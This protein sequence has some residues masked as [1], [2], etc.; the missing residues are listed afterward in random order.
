MTIHAPLQSLGL[1]DE[2]AA[3]RRAALGANRIEEPRSRSLA[4][5]I[6]GA[7]REPMFLLLFAAT[8]LYLLLGDLAEGLFLLAGAT[9]A[10]GLVVAQQARSERALAAL[11]LLAEP[12]ARVLRSSVERRLP[13]SDLVPDDVILVGEGERLPADAMLISGDALQV[14]ESALT[15]ES[16]PVVK[17]PALPAAGSRDDE[18]VAR[19]YAGTMLVQG[20]GVAVVLRTGQQTRIGAIGQSLAGIRQEPT[21]LQKTSAGLVGRLGVAAVAFCVLVALAYGLLRDDWIGGALAG[22]TVGISLIPEEFPMVLAIFLALGA[23]RLARHQVLVRRPA[24]IETLGAV[25]L[26][27]VD[28]TGTLTENRMSVVAVWR[29][30]RLWRCEDGALAGP[31][32]G[33]VIEIAALASAVRPSDPMDRAVREM[34]TGSGI[35]LAE[36][37]PLRSYPL[38]PDRLAFIQVWPQPSSGVLLAAKGAPEAICR[39]CGLSADARAAVEQTVV[40]MAAAGLRVLG[41]AAL[42]RSADGGEDPGDLAFEF[43]GLVGFQDPVRADVPPA[44]AQARAAGISVVMITGDYPATAVEIAR[45]CGIDVTAGVLTGAEIDAL[46]AAELVDRVRTV[47]VFARVSPE[48]KLRL[49]E[50]FKACGRLVAMT[51]DGVNDAPALEAAHVGIAMGQRGTDVAREAA[52]LILLDDRFASIVGGVRL[53]RRITAN[54][55]KALIYIVAIHVPIAGLALLPILLGLPPVLYPLQVVVLELVIDPVC[56]LVFE[57]EPSEEQAMRRPPAPASE[58]L[59]GL[60]QVGLGLLQGFAVLVGALGL[61]SWLIAA[62]APPSE[63]RAMAFGV[64]VAANLGLAMGLAASRGVR[65]FDPR[66][67]VFWSIAFVAAAMLALAIYAPPVAAVF[68][69]SAPDPLWL[70]LALAAAA[71][72]GAGLGL[73]RRLGQGAL[74][75][76]PAAG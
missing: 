56:S 1:T 47:T 23:W 61:Y 45:D 74:Q 12:T 2:E 35:A 19:L 4:A 20:Q 14:D 32:L 51:G 50:A 59:F 26:L 57:A 24:V 34:A 38:R 73:L 11:R 37:A 6:L 28:K 25:S 71:G 64:L 9:A 52:D 62:G 16:A 43:E 15:G 44:L 36:A 18:E 54:L 60:R 21:R 10:I 8:A 41:V 66:H 58:P 5:V 13:A 39:L 70:A 27:A 75:T 72:S 65:L 33:R 17:C 46:S 67:A 3:R 63:S 48:Q 22:I 49:V 55:R 76:S 53:G 42:K 68:R 29:D 31:E 30:G 7:L 69:F 40:E